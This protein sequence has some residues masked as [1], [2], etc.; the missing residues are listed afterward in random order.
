MA[1]KAKAVSD[2]CLP[3]QISVGTVPLTIQM[4]RLTPGQWRSL[5]DAA[6]VTAPDPEKPGHVLKKPDDAKFADLL[7]E[8]VVSGVL[9]LTPDKV[10]RL[11]ELDPDGDQPVP[12]ASGNI[13]SREFLK[14]LWDTLPTFASKIIEANALMLEAAKVQREADLGNSASSSAP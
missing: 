3:M 2:I 4:R 10:E 14:F 11:I 7:F 8:A 1:F 9:D 6:S 5:N 13:T 12:D